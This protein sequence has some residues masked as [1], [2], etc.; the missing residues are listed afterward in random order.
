MSK[1]R[2][3]RPFTPVRLEAI[4]LRYLERFSSSAENLRRV[5]RRRVE[6]AAHLDGEDPG[7]ALI[8]I[9]DLVGRWQRSGL[10]DDRQYA[11]MKGRSLINRGRSSRTIR[12]HLSTRGVDADIIDAT[13]TCLADEAVEQGESVDLT[14]ARAYA[15]RRRLGPWRTAEMRGEMRDRDLAAMGRAGFSWDVARSVIDGEAG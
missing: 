1:T 15:R 7:P 6:R 5:L 11:E 8:L 10:L 9:D 3:S 14:A 2:T 4:A 13:L 12:Q